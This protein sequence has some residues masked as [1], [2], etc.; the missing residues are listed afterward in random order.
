MIQMG[1]KGVVSAGDSA[2]RLALQREFAD[3][4]CVSLP[5]LL[6]PALVRDV[7]CRI[8]TTEWVP[9]AYG[10][11]ATEL[12]MHDNPVLA[13][14]LLLV[15]DEALFGLLQQLAGCAAIRGFMGRVYRMMPGAAHQASW[16][17]DVGH[18][19]LLGMSVDLSETPYAG[20][21]FE[22]RERA[23]RRILS[24]TTSRRVGDATLF[25]IGT[26]VEHQVT[27]LE[28]AG[29]RTVFA[30]WFS[31]QPLFAELVKTGAVVPNPSQR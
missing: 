12:C 5:G 14:L 22:L 17:T 24:R 2:S 31:A 4:R 7:L 25:R 10:E 20:G 27:A 1:R 30:G 16:H 8:R 19:R 18:E 6:E 13:L 28:G 26:D 11:F 21:I 15:N 23:S 29:P 9:Q 3:K